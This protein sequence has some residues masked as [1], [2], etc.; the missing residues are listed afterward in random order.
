M[1]TN[2]E[3]RE[4]AQLVRANLKSLTMA[5]KTAAAMGQIPDGSPNVLLKAYYAQ[6]GHKDLKTWMQWRDAGYSVKKGEKALHLWSSPKTFT[7]KPKGITPEGLEAPDTVEPGMLEPAAQ[8]ETY[9][10]YSYITLFSAK[11]VEKITE[12]DARRTAAKKAAPAVIPVTVTA[13][14]PA[15]AD[16]DLLPF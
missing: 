1:K 4:S 9:D 7:R 16:S 2:K 10:A 13:A 6:K 15:T 8:P 14:A 12:R 3:K 11:Q 5:L